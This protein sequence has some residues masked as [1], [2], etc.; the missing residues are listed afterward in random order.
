MSIVGAFDV[1]RR[2]LTFE[3]LDT[4]TG[5]LRRGR[6]VPADREHLREWLARVAGQDDVHFALAG[7]TGWRDVT[8]EP[9]PAGAEPHLAEPADTAA[10]R[11]R[12]RHAKTDKTD[13]RH[14]RVR[15]R[16]PEPS[17]QSIQ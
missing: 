17:G 8:G 16:C 9:A 10:L 7:C 3:Y 5:E 11:G 12:K 13:T 4:A 15:L 1:H 2:Q 14:L 6:V